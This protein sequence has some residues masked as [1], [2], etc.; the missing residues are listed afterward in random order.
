MSRFLRWGGPRELP[1]RTGKPLAGA[2]IVLWPNVQWGCGTSH[3]FM[4]R[5]Y[6]A[7]S[8]EEGRAVVQNLPPCPLDDRDGYRVTHEHFWMPLRKQKYGPPERQGTVVL[9]SGIIKEITVR[10]ERRPVE[11]KGKK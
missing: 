1:A 2:T 10:L 3:Y 7:V 6:K 5:E 8:N 4:R 11:Q 9:K